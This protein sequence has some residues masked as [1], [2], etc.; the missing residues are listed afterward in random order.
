M[1]R[2]K[3]TIQETAEYEIMVKATNS[4][5]AAEAAEE[6]FLAEGPETSLPCTVLERD[7][8]KVEKIK[9]KKI[10]PGG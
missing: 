7:A 1:P 8:I 4:D 6:V 2:Y 3:V 10:N 5:L 9:P